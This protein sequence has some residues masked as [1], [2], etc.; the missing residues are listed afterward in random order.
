MRSIIPMTVAERQKFA[1]V[2]EVNN[3]GEVTLITKDEGL[4]LTSALLPT[5]GYLVPETENT[6]FDRTSGLTATFTLEG[7]F[8]TGFKTPQFTGTKLR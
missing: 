7:D 8:V 3:L 6:F 4:E 5:P 1:G 2:Y